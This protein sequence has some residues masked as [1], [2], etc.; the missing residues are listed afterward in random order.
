MTCPPTLGKDSAKKAEIYRKHRT[1]HKNGGHLF[2]F[3]T[4]KK[5]NLPSFF[6]HLLYQ[7]SD[8]ICVGVAWVWMIL[9]VRASVGVRQRGLGGDGRTRNLFSDGFRTTDDQTSSEIS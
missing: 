1:C 3:L 4:V 6:V 5:T 9:S 7:V 8:C 2:T